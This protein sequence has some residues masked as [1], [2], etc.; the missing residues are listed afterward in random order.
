MQRAPLAGVDGGRL[1]AA[2]VPRLG[3]AKVGK[4]AR[5]SVAEQRALLD[6]LGGSGILS[7]EE[8]LA[9]IR[10]ASVPAF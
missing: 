4:L 9:A 2:L 7:R 1:G 6:I 3:Y 8:S 10:K 5:Q